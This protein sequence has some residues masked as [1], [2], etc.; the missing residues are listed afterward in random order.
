[1]GKT[2]MKKSRVLLVK[3]KN[4]N[5]NLKIKILKIHHKKITHKS[6]VNIF[7]IVEFN[8]KLK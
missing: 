4:L 1:M 7:Q 8:F 2:M 6:K 5:L 3:V